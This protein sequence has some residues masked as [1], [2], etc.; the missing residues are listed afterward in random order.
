MAKK[1]KVSKT[2][3]VWHQSSQ[4]ATLSKM[5]KY[6]GFACGTGVQGDTKYN[7][8]KVKRQFMKELDSGSF[9]CFMGKNPWPSRIPALLRK[10]LPRRAQALLSL[11]YK[12]PT[13]QFA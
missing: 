5:P 4:E 6:N 10:A 12:L 1:H 3:P 11:R 9:Y 13:G 8:K 2:G 7:R